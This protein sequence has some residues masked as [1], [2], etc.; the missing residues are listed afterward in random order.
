MRRGPAR[1]TGPARAPRDA[2]PGCGH[3][4]PPD[5]DG[6]CPSCGLRTA[7]PTPRTTWRPSWT[8][9]RRSATAGT[10]APAT[11]TPSRWAGSVPAPPTSAERVA[12]AVC[13]GVSSTRSSELAARAAADA[14]LVVLLR[15]PG[16]E[17][18]HPQ[19]GRPPP[20]PRL[21]RSCRA[22]PRNRRRA[23][24]SAR[25]TTCR[26]ACSP[27]A[28]WVTAAPT[29]SRTG[30]RRA[31]PAAERGPH[32][33]G[34][35]RGRDSGSGRRRDPRPMPSPGGSARTETPSRRSSRSPRRARRAPALH[36]RALEVPPRRGGA[37]RRRPSRAGPRRCR[38]AAAAALTAAALAAGGADNVTVA[39]LPVTRSGGAMTVASTVAA[40][41]TV[42]VDQN[43]YL[44]PGATRVDAVVTVTATGTGGTPA[45]AL[46]IIVVD[47]LRVDGRRE[48]PLRPAGDRGGDRGAARRRRVRGDRRRPPGASRS[49]R[50]PAPPG[51]TSGPAP[52]P[53]RARRPAARG[54]RHRDRRLAARGPTASPTGTRTRVRHAILLTDGQNGEDAPVFAPALDA[55][56]SARSPAT[57]AAWAPTGGSTSCARSRRRCSA[58]STSSPG[59]TTWPPTSAR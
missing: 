11:R 50:T 35:R 15:G 23:R 32:R 57:A 1:A 5:D 49:T 38:R 56:A 34:R 20:R 42:Q 17:S 45:D 59:P 22:A 51:R 6:W 7:G 8:V 25:C 54:R 18:G 3:P 16:G 53:R 26:A 10:S 37:R 58:R 43:P 31:R 21:P 55:A 27:S 33:R 19:R 24:W 48:D 47:C 40:G 41:F 14:A 13:D 30:R 12:A 36:R 9:A 52:R 44:A 2:C 4:P 29:G 28:G 39:V 46:E